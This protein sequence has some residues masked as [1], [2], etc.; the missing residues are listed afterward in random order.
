[1]KKYL[2]ILCTLFLTTSLYA[3]KKL[4]LDE[5]ISIALQRNSSLIQSKNSLEYSKTQLKSA[6]GNLLPSLGLQGSWNW[7]RTQDIG[8][9][10]I[11]YLGNLIE[12][13]LTSTDTRSYSVG[14]GGSWVL[15]NG[16]AN[17]SG[18]SQAS[19]NLESA[20]LDLAKL[21]Q[22]LVYQTTELYYAIA[23]AKALLEVQRENVKYNRKF[24]ETVQER[25]RLGAVP[26]ADVYAQ[27]YQL[28][29]AELL[30]IQAENSYENAK[31]TLL[32]FLA[33]DV[34]EEYEFEDPFDQSEIINSDAYLQEFKS[35]AKM[36][37]EA[38]NNRYDYQ[39]Q[40]YS[41]E[42]AGSGVIIARSGLFPSLNGNYSYGT[43]ALKTDNLFDRKVWNV[44][45]TL[46][47]PIFSN[48]NTEA[49][50]EYAAAQELNAQEQLN[51][52]ERQVKIEVK[53]GYLDF[54]AGKK[55]LDVATKNVL[56]AEENRKMNYERYSL[57]SGT[58]L[59]VLQSD[60]D[61]TDAMRTKINAQFDFYRL[62][63][64]LVNYL[65]KLDYK[66]Y[67]K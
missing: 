8:G 26:M 11:D 2:L 59:D 32:N 41:V 33:L 64:R 56:A 21:K 48:W 30:E 51:A 66:N 38:L 36:V 47:L 27:Q 61:Y 18:I 6:W 65:G 23:S 29:N 55:S 58:I 53:Q 60:R 20:K 24:L 57:G 46:S 45:L 7:S 19:D 31:G 67:E 63:D 49:Q 14:A 37:E 42:S 52:L 43:S 13:P 17:I 16:L 4:T 35:I 3:Q 5:A 15:F 25:N 28:G 12:V 40:K 9:T 1:M 10:Q 54:V 44:S 34:L 62:K 50:I 39:S 22:D